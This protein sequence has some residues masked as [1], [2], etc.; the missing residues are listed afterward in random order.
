MLYI[1]NWTIVPDD[2]PFLGHHVVTTLYMSQVRV[3]EA[4]HISA[5]TLMWSGEFSNPL[6][7]GHVITRFAIQMTEDGTLWHIVHPFLELMFA[8]VYFV[9]RALL[10]PV[11]IAHITYDLLTREGRKNI[12][13][14]ISIGWIIMIWGILIGSIP[15]TKE[16]YEMALDGLEVKYHKD[17]DYGPGYEL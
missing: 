2:I 6:Q 17:Y 4:G 11:Q 10:G 7:N 9:F 12:P 8:I 5:M 15:W 16:C 13:L 14:Y 1:K 3:L